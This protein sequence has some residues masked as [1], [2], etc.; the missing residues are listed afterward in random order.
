MAFE[1]CA[2]RMVNHP[3]KKQKTLRSAGGRLGSS[4]MEFESCFD[5]TVNSRL[6]R[7]LS[8]VGAWGRFI[9]RNIFYVRPGVGASCRFSRAQIVGRWVLNRGYHLRTI[10]IWLVH[11]FTR[12]IPLFCC[13]IGFLFFLAVCLSGRG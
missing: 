9:D 7:K 4:P 2:D 12:S 3:Y 6:K 5:R 8:G 10:D 11:T 13:P 1:S